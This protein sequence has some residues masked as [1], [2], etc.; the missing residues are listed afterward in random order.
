MSPRPCTRWT[1][2][3]GNSATY[4]AHKF[5]RPKI[6]LEPRKEVFVEDEETRTA[7]HEVGHLLIAWRATRVRAVTVA[8]LHEKG[9]NVGYELYPVDGKHETS[10]CIKLAGIAAEMMVF[11]NFRAAP[12]KGDLLEARG[13]LDAADLKWLD[14][15]GHKLPT[16]FGKAYEDPPSK[17]DEHKLQCAYA[18]AKAILM[19]HEVVHAHLVSHLLSMKR[20][21]AAHLE[22]V[23][24]TRGFLKVLANGKALFL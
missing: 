7:V 21:D 2:S 22:R 18:M 9:G 1:A 20:I 6:K 13:I 12:S 5:L 17:E 3:H 11:R 15:R 23:F 19:E 4:L 8:W 10:L 16:F 24:G 14:P